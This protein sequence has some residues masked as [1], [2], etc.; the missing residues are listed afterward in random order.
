MGDETADDTAA[1][2]SAIDAA[3]ALGGGTVYF[4]RGV[5]KITA[6]LT[7]VEV[8]L[9]GQGVFD[10]NDP[11]LSGSTLSLS[12][13]LETTSSHVITV[14]GE[15]GRV[16]GLAFYYP[17]EVGSNTSPAITA[18]GYVVQ[19]GPGGTRIVRNNYFVNVPYAI[20]NTQGWSEISHNL[21]CAT[22]VGIHDNQMYAEHQI[23]FN[24]IT[25][26]L[27]QHALPRP[28]ENAGLDRSEHDRLQVGEH[29]CDLHRQ[30]RVRLLDGFPV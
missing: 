5:Y 2:Q 13:G 15:G 1:I 27:G 19:L 22:R 17:T 29:A 10:I 8:R 25:V 6:P 14:T 12:G 9:L 11:T 20:S 21:I 23:N 16:E 30:Q 3:E 28:P 18:T 24:Q 4:P 7:A 26:G